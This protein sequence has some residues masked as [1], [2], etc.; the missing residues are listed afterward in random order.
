MTS[1]RDA[2]PGD[3]FPDVDLPDSDGNLRRLSELAGGDPLVVHTYRG[4]WCPK[5]RAYARELVALQPA[6]EVAYSRLVSISVDPAEVSAAF[7]A[8]LDARWTFLSDAERVWLPRL[9]LQELTD[10]VHDPYLPTVWV[11]RP[12]L[13]VHRAWAGYWYWGRPSAHELRL[14]LREVT[15]A[16]REDW[17]P[18]RAAEAPE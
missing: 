11:L 5:E 8:G 9:G 12:D 16:V 17:E 14:A 15:A 6:M 4:W 2:H 13:T 1:M 18:P 3:R 7:R 10:T